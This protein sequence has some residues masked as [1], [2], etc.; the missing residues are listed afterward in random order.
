VGLECGFGHSLD[1]EGWSLKAALAC[2][3][4]LHALDKEPRLVEAIPESDRETIRAAL[5]RKADP[6]Q[7]T[8]CCR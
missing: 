7:K 8:S 4:C 6:D 1:P 2:P 5:K 3:Y